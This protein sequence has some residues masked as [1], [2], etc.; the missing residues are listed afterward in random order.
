VRKDKKASCQRLSRLGSVERYARFT[1][2][3]VCDSV[4]ELPAYVLSPE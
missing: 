3:T 1:Q 2:L 4:A